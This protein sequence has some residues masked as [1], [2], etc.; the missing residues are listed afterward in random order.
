MAILDSFHLVEIKARPKRKGQFDDILEYILRYEL[1]IILDENKQRMAFYQEGDFFLQNG[2]YIRH[3]IMR[4]LAT[5]HKLYPDSEQIKRYLQ[6][7]S[8]T[9][10]A[11]LRRGQDFN[12]LLY[13]PKSY[14]KKVA[15]KAEEK[16][17]IIMKRP[18]GRPRK[19]A[20]KRYHKRR[21]AHPSGRIYESIA[22]AARQENENYNALKAKAL[23]DMK[24]TL[25]RL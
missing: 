20:P 14:Q 8:D 6:S 2:E 4:R 9:I 17:S 21:Y 18:V 7:I 19:T 13:T 10:Y 15:I 16:E 5:E 12:A 1:Q 11:L 23:Y 24:K 3:E 25:N 22:E